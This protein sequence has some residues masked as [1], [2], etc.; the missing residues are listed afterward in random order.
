MKYFLALMGLFLFSFTFLF[1]QNLK[2]KTK[3][4]IDTRIMYHQTKNDQN[5]NLTSALSS[6]INPK[7]SIKQFENNTILLNEKLSKIHNNHYTTK[8][9][10]N[11]DKLFLLKVKDI[12]SNP[13]FKQ[14]LLKSTKTKITDTETLLKNHN[15]LN[16][17]AKLLD[18]L[19]KLF[20]IY[21]IPNN[22]RKNLDNQ[23]R[24]LI[25]DTYW[26]K[27]F[28]TTKEN[29]YKL[30]AKQLAQQL[31]IPDKNRAVKLIFWFTYSRMHVQRIEENTPFK[32]VIHSQIGDC[33][34][35][36]T[37]NAFLL[38]NNKIKIDLIV[39]STE[40]N[41]LIIHAIV[42]YNNIYYLDYNQLTTADTQKSY[43][44]TLRKHMYN[45]F[46][47]PMNYIKYDTL[48]HEN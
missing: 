7:T 34:E 25:R 13:F 33:L 38:K 32:E 10:T 19:A 21:L 48:I 20:S 45:D 18:N 39:I 6:L 42:D 43:Y 4:N 1:S 24:D 8:S 9:T 23:Y 30:S 35:F 41:H 37:L 22:I 15:S 3:N 36:G 28:K 29:Y 17:Y 27:E 44:D 11:T 26:L 47:K 40:N 2:T 5:D 16:N 31:T 46:H 14:N 12:V